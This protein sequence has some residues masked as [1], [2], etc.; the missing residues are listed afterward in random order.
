MP[1]TKARSGTLPWKTLTVSVFSEVTNRVTVSP[2]AGTADSAAS[3]RTAAAPFA[4]F[5]II[6]SSLSDKLSQNHLSN[7]TGPS[8]AGARLIGVEVHAREP[9]LA[10]VR[11]DPLDDHPSDRRNR[12]P[13]EPLLGLG[14]PEHRLLLAVG[15][16]PL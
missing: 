6:P 9:L 5:R 16:P 12:N 11:L 2:A 3:R 8:G 4:V 13:T 15:P 14:G 7:A 10:G 1:L